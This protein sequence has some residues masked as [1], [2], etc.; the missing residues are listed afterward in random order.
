M[1][2]DDVVT[3]MH[4]FNQIPFN[5]SNTFSPLF[6]WC[7]ESLKVPTAR[8]P[9]SSGGGGVQVKRRPSGD[10]GSYLYLLW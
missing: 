9:G 8:R 10:K 1:Q 4:G 2:W 5:A 6:R 3:F 7:R